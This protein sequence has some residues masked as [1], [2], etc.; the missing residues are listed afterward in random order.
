MATM[1]YILKSI[2]QTSINQ[3]CTK[4]GYNHVSS[5]HLSATKSFIWAQPRKMSLMLNSY[6]HNI[7]TNL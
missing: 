5:D 7:S 6:N 2:I 4:L 1:N 3:F